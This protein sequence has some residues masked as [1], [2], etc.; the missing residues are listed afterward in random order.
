[1]ARE[2]TR[3]YAAPKTTGRAVSR[4]ELGG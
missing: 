3:A 4:V 1:M 2:G